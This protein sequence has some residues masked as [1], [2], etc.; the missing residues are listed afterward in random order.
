[1]EDASWERIVLQAGGNPFPFPKSGCFWACQQCLFAKKHSQ[2]FPLL[3]WGWPSYNQPGWSHELWGD[4]ICPLTSRETKPPQQ[5]WQQTVR[6]KKIPGKKRFFSSNPLLFI[7]FPWN[8]LNAL[9]LPP[10]PVFPNVL[11]GSKVAT[12]VG[13]CRMAKAEV[14]SLPMVTTTQLWNSQCFTGVNSFL[15][16]YFLSFL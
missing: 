2:L 11:A 3:S 15:L 10:L 8:S 4:W 5:K 9:V 14:S 7:V 12:A 13:E 16:C 6:W 1:M